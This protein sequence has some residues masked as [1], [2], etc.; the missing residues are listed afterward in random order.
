MKGDKRIGEEGS[1]KQ[2]TKKT[3][4]LWNEFKTAVLRIQERFQKYDPVTDKDAYQSV[5][6]ELLLLLCDEKYQSILKGMAK[7]SGVHFHGSI[8]FEDVFNSVVPKILEKYDPNY[9][10]LPHIDFMFS[11]RAIDLLRKEKDHDSLD[12]ED[13]DGT[14]FLDKNLP[15]AEKG[16]PE[17]STLM[18]EEWNR[19]FLKFAAMV[20]N[21]SKRTERGNQT[22]FQ[23]FE[24]FYT[25]DLITGSMIQKEILLYRYT[26]EL[27]LAAS[28]PFVNHVDRNGG[29]YSAERLLSPEDVY[30][31]F[32][33]SEKDAAWIPGEGERPV[34]SP[35]DPPMKL[36]VKNGVYRGYFAQVENRVIASSAIS[37]QL[38]R[39]GKQKD[40]W[41]EAAENDSREQLTEDL[42]VFEELG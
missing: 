16:N 26:R 37:Q 29:E 1:L 39:Y 34:S 3:S 5:K 6:N 11:H 31:I 40:E 30:G 24:K 28:V 32:L 22:R 27:L 36:P 9:P 21:Y 20:L 8:E 33:K 18:L 17:T 19:T 13:A 12:Q 4:R 15:G 10:L 25:G 35:S 7:K 23:Y 2:N 14:P 42:G 38:S 41:R